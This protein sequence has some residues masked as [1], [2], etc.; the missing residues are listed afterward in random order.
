MESARLMLRGKRI[1]FNPL[2]CIAGNTLQKNHRV[3]AILVA[4]EV[5]SGM[6]YVWQRTLH[7]YL[8]ESV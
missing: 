2:T 4:T 3:S 5:C 6:F 1:L 7:I 8:T